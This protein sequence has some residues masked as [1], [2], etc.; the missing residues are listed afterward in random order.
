MTDPNQLSRRERQIMDVVFAGQVVSVQEI[1]AALP[2]PPTPMAVRRMLAILME[3]KYLRRKKRGR[4]FMYFPQQSKKRAG[5][6]ALR[7]VL[8]TYFDGS[9]D[10]ALAMHLEKPG[11][12]LTDEDIDR[13]TSLINDLSKKRE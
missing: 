7:K 5:L 9:V 12:N 1:C 8:A 13:L 6:K 3:K 10:A 4:E 11:A 2:D